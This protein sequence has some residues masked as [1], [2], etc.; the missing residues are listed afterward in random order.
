M[1]ESIFFICT[2]KSPK[3][4][5]FDLQPAR[6]RLRQDVTKQII[7]GKSEY[8]GYLEIPYPAALRPREPHKMRA[9]GLPWPGPAPNFA[10]PWAHHAFRA[11]HV[12]LDIKGG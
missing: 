8:W 3:H 5:G 12:N 2:N 10:G 7:L 9:R 11:E 4:P 6:S 1:T